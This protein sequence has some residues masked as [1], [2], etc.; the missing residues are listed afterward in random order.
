MKMKNPWVG[1]LDRGYTQIRQ[2]VI[3]RFRNLLPEVTDF[4]DS[5]IFMIILDYVASLVE[6][7]NYYIDNMARESYI[8]TAQHI[9][10]LVQQS[11]LIDYR[12]KPRVAATVELM[13]ELRD[14]EGN[15]NYQDKDI[16]I[17]KGTV[18]SGKNNI[19]FIT[20]KDKTLPSGAVRVL[21]NAE[22]V[23]RKTDIFIGLVPE[24]GGPV[25]MLPIDYNDG[26][27][28]LNIGGETW[29]LRN[30][31]AFSHPLDKHFI[32]DYWDGGTFY[33]RFGDGNH[34]LKPKV[35]QTVT[36]NYQSTYGEIGN[37]E[38]QSIT[39]LRSLQ[40]EGLD[41]NHQITV[42]NP[43]PATGGSNRE[44]LEELREHLGCSL[45][46]LDRAV[47]YEDFRDIA[48]LCPGVDKVGLD[49][50]CEYGVIY[51]IT[52]DGGGLATQELLS[53]LIAFINPRKVMGVPVNAKPAG[54]SGIKI[55][56]KVWGKYGKKYED[57]REEIIETLVEEYSY[58][59]SDINMAVNTSDIIAL[60]DNLGTV[61]H[62]DLTHLSLIPF[63]RQ[64]M[65]TTIPFPG[66][67]ELIDDVKAPEYMEWSVLVADV[68]DPGEAGYKDG[69]V[70]FHLAKTTTDGSQQDIVYTSPYYEINLEHPYAVAIHHQYLRI[71]LDITQKLRLG[72][73]WSFSTYEINTNIP[74]DDNSVPVLY[75][76]NI[77][78]DIIEQSY[79]SWK[80]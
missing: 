70:Q 59:N 71:T 76:D 43:S 35:G 22:Q 3:S 64:Q 10:S 37:L 4:S 52:P 24:E 57:I 77:N 61:D 56:M 38:A 34:G 36:I 65:N 50:K 66:S 44:S 1:Y 74:V 46:T 14:K 58:N 41:E 15:L 80:E 9:S 67:I 55:S 53:R 75:R 51:Y 5:N 13:F 8:Y 23:E 54:E 29:D 63:A 62:L 40:Q 28:S 68:K 32:V 42:Y 33:V 7:L 2:A 17:K 48:K 78:L 20:T 72:Y 79:D 47:T 31:L 11:R 60:V 73:A 69:A 21:V 27:G 39:T 19:T 45:R 26:S 30:T 18:V 25:L 6:L 16:L 12:M 49:F